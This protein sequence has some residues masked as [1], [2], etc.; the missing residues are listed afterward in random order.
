MSERIYSVD[1]A[2]LFRLKH[3]RRVKLQL[4]VF[5]RS[6]PL[7]PIHLMKSNL[8]RSLSL[9]LLSLA[10]LAT[11]AFAV[12]PFPL[13]SNASSVIQFGSWSG[14]GTIQ[15]D[16]TPGNSSTGVGNAAKI[17]VDNFGAGVLTINN[18]GGDVFTSG[19]LMTNPVSAI[20]TISLTGG[21]ADLRL[22]NSNTFDGGATLHNSIGLEGFTGV[23]AVTW[24]TRYTRPIAGRNDTAGIGS[25]TT[26]PMGAGLALI[27]A[28]TGQTVSSFTVG[29][30]YTQI[31]QDNNGVVTPG[32]PSGATPRQNSGFGTAVAG[33]TSFTSNA[34]NNIDEFL[35]V[36]GYD[37]NGNGWE[38]TDADN[39]YMQEMT[40]TIRRDDNAAFASNTL[41]VFSMDGQQY[42]NVNII[43]EPASV[44][45]LVGSCV[46]VCLLRRRRA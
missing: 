21:T 32:V 10:A 9:G 7:T 33:A 35:L 36:R 4:A 37:V 45:L 13:E 14:N 15:P 28:G 16:V 3:P 44:M 41:F 11:P 29:L 5:I 1:L 17:L 42:S 12:F 23:T 43:P 18:M 20:H 26:R 25:L 34:F 31:F 30:N 27:T 22:H 46:G 6:N 8:S 24:T 19:R 2:K 39:V 40:W 38:A